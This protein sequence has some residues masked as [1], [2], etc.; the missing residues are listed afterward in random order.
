MAEEFLRLNGMSTRNA[1]VL[2]KYLTKVYNMG[3]E[4]R[5]EVVANLL[6]NLMN[7]DV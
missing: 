7:E 3:Y 1:V 2:G 4:R 5:S 6:R